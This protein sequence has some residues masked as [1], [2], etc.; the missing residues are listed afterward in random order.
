MRP[1]K[2][3]QSVDDFKIRESGVP[4]WGTASH[5]IAP[6]IRLRRGSGMG[7]GSAVLLALL[8]FCGIAAVATLKWPNESR[9]GL[10]IARGVALSAIDDLGI[11]AEQAAPNSAPKSAPP[12]SAVPVSSAV[13]SAATT[14]APPGARPALNPRQTI[15]FQQIAEGRQ[16]AVR[17]TARSSWSGEGELQLIVVDDEDHPV[18]N[19]R[20]RVVSVMPSTATT[21]FDDFTD[22]YG[23]VAVGP[24]GAGYVAITI[25]AK[26]VRR[27]MRANIEPGRRTDVTLATPVGAAVIGVVRDADGRPIPGA[28]IRSAPRPRAPGSEGMI[29][30]SLK[31]VSDA[32]G[33]YRMINVPVGEHEL[34]VIDAAHPRRVAQVQI[35]DVPYHGTLT[36]DLSSSPLGAPSP[37]T[38]LPNGVAAARSESRSSAL[39]VARRA[40]PKHATGTK[41]ASHVQRQK[42]V[43]LPSRSG[44]PTQAPVAR[45]ASANATEVTGVTDTRLRFR[46]T[47][48]RG[49]PFVGDV[50]IALL[51]TDGAA[52]AS[53]TNLT[54][55]GR[56]V[57]TFDEAIPGSYRISLRATGH[58]PATLLSE[59]TPGSNEIRA[60]LARLPDPPARYRLQGTIVDRTTG[61][62]IADCRVV[63]RGE[64][65]RFAFSTIDGRFFVSSP[66]ARPTGVWVTREGYAS[67]LTIAPENGP[68]SVRMTPRSE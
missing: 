11:A 61:H 64:P 47:D 25:D 36:R 63:V 7:L 57:A 2:Q 20:V 10:E 43:A 67:E 21:P 12:T 45:R 42:T 23:R 1:E 50:T 39:S 55:Y 14:R 16:M 27:T 26:T 29:E 54:V 8:L 38:H 66:D 5:G 9:R 37:A 15:A 44:A 18:P 68:L 17:R 52:H 48:E 60:I 46:L 33:V 32:N 28:T 6:F 58:E 53:T 19:A 51:P 62:P 24:L 30:D 56:G 40:T 41:S 59:I 35:L 31:A 65:D 22:E 3:P 4:G 13:V 34:L 49:E